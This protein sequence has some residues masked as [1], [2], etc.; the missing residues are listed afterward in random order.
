LSFLNNSITIPVRIKNPFLETVYPI[1]GEL[2]GILD[3]SY[4]GFVLVP[5]SVYSALGLGNRKTIKALPA[6]GSR[7]DLTGDYAT[8]EFSGIG[9]TVDGL[10]QTCK[11]AKEVL[12]GTDAVR[13]LLISIHFCNKQVFI[14]RCG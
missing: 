3:T 7:I 14:E 13:K 8:L 1:S 6:N 5:M 9:I 2:Q 10:V 12:L 4:S 11:G